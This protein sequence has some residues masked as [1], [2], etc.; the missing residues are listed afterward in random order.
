MSTDFQGGAWC[1]T[2]PKMVCQS[3]RSITAV[4]KCMF[5]SLQK[6]SILY[7]NNLGFIVDFFQILILQK[8]IR[9]R[10]MYLAS[11]PPPRDLTYSF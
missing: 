1:T 2:H 8:R 3:L 9:V 5:I 4:F 6:S 11:A 10:Y 7:F